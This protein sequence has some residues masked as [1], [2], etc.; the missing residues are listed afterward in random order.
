MIDCKQFQ[1][2]FSAT[3]EVIDRPFSEHLENCT[4][5]AEFARQIRELQQ[6]LYA[7]ME[8]RVP[9]SLHPKL[10]R[11]PTERRKQ[12]LRRLSLGISALAASVLLAI[13]LV[14][15]RPVQLPAQTKLEQVVYQH[16]AREPEALTAVFPV[17]QALV[18]STLKDFGVEVS[19]SEFGE[20]MHV[21]LCPIGDTHGLHLVVQGKQGPVTLLF[22]PTKSIQVRTPFAQGHFTGY[23]EPAAVGLVAIVGEKGENLDRY[24]RAVKQSMHWL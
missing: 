15:F 1:K 5:C 3:P 2:Q 10:K 17:K 7:A 20:I 14:H 18:T 16:I 8:V 19:D 21:T 12:S 22:M 4:E 13:G 9:V 11:I 6:R 23:I 24:E